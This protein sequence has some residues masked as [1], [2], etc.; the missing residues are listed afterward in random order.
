MST[1]MQEAPEDL[2]IQDIQD[3]SGLSWYHYALLIIA[4]V[5]ALVYL[6]EEVLED[7]FIARNFGVVEAG[8]IYRSGQISGSLIE[9]ILIDNGIKVIIDLN[10]ID[11]GKIGEYQQAELQAAQK[12]NIEVLRFPLRGNG[13]GSI[14]TYAD[15]VEAIKKCHDEHRPVLVH[16]AAGAQRT[17]GVIASYRM[18]V[19]GKSP[20]F[21][22]EELCQ[23]ESRRHKNETVVGYVNDN[24]VELASILKKRGVIESEPESA[25]VMKLH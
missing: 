21:A 3:R 22:V 18:L 15:A 20:E 19:E 7:R 13:T 1:L 6:W 14:E 23:Y 12:H 5:A 4:P 24:I 11:T 25:P 17:G 10:G 2:D 8:E 16:C 9:G